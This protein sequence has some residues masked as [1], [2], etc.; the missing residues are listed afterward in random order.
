MSENQNVNV[1]LYYSNNCGH[2]I[3]FKPK[4]DKFKHL[5]QKY[6]GLIKKHFKKN[7]IVTEFEYN[8]ENLQIFKK[9]NIYSFPTIMINNSEYMDK[10]N[11]RN[12]FNYILPTLFI[13]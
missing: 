4:W 6:D 1:T 9:D 5:C 2:C 12:L 8:P 3:V 11:V 13:Q 7:I 10:R